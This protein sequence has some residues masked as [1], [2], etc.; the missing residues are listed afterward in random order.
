MAETAGPPP[1]T[2]TQGASRRAP[3]P[4]LTPWPEPHR[5]SPAPSSS[6]PIPYA[7]SRNRGQSSKVQ[8]LRQGELRQWHRFHAVVFAGLP[9]WFCTQPYTQIGTHNH[10]SIHTCVRA[11]ASGQRRQRSAFQATAG[12]G[13]DCW[14]EGR[15]SASRATLR[16]SKNPGV[17]VKQHTGGQVGRHPGLN[18]RQVCHSCQTNQ[19]GIIQPK[20]T[21]L[22]ASSQCWSEGQTQSLGPAIA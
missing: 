2:R 14:C 5:H 18:T 10:T 1:W 16:R 3:L 15:P 21:I 20:A 9:G 7:Q 22:A 4:R 13:W 12:Q 6:A 11:A 17:P 19:S 8:L